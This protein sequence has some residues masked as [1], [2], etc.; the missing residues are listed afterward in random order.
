MRTRSLDVKPCPR[1]GE[2]I[3]LSHPNGSEAGI[4]IDAERSGYATRGKTASKGGVFGITGNGRPFWGDK[5]EKMTKGAV[6]YHRP[7]F[8]SCTRGK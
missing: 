1:C 7:H 6:H 4:W 2:G 3:R 5:L 8:I